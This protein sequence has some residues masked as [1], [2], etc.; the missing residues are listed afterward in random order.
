MYNFM[1]QGGDPE[2]TGMGGSDEKIFG[3][4]DD[5]GHDNDIS[6]KRGV[7]SMARSQLYNSASSQFF[8]CNADSE[9]S[10]DG[11]YAAFGYVIA[12]M[13]VVDSITQITIQYANPSS[14]YTIADKSKQAVISRVDVISEKQALEYVK[15]STK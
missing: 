3:E 10:L 5:N 12:G 6:H 7:I 4:F 11:K 1:I 13:S 9:Y 8:I 2:A 15:L 14:S